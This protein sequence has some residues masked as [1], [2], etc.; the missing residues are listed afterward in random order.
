M[1]IGSLFMAC[2]ED[3]HIAIPKNLQEYIDLNSERTLDE[4][5]ACAASG[6]EN[7][8]LT[9]IFYYPI[10]GATNI[11]YYELSDVNA[12]E[13]NLTLYKRKTLSKETVFGGKLERFVRLDTSESWCIIT[14]LT[15]GKLHKSNPIRLKNQ[16]KPTEW[17]N[18]VSI[19]FT[20]S[21]M[22]NFSWN[23]G[24]IEEN[25]IYFQVISNTD[26]SFIS[27]TYTVAK[28]FQYYNTSNVVLHINISTPAELILDTDYNFTLMGVSE[29]NWVNLVIEKTF[30][31]I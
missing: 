12:D 7:T 9:S 21:L 6:K 28:E 24:A 2:S 20:T 26:N 1:C 5:I 8:N 29:D 25:V 4:V 30:T 16:T 27:G 23:D 3:N 14:Y 10:E 11:R 13:Q 17:K 19:D 22:P 15:D 31:A 18:E